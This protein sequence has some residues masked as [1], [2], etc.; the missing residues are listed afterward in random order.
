MLAANWQSG[1]VWRNE[2][3]RGTVGDGSVKGPAG[4]GGFGP[5]R[6]VIALFQWVTFNVKNM[7]AKCQKYGAHDSRAL[8]NTECIAAVPAPQA[9]QA[10]RPSGG[11]PMTPVRRFVDVPNWTVAA[12]RPTTCANASHST[13]SPRSGSGSCPSWPGTRQDGPATVHDV[14]L[15]DIRALARQHGFRTPRGPPDLTIAGF[16]GLAGF[17]TP[18]FRTFP[19]ARAALRSHRRGHHAGSGAVAAPGV[20]TT[21]CSALAKGISLSGI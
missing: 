11:W 15:Q 14:T 5:E 19:A 9:R 18:D 16:A 10:A 4:G 6:P 20:A 21:S 7:G 2:D 12:T 17:H 13:P 3:A 1:A 8:L